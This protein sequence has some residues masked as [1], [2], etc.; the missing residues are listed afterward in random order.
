VK[1][2]KSID[3][4]DPLTK[5]EVIKVLNIMEVKEVQR[6]DKIFSKG[7]EAKELFLLDIGLV[8]AIGEDLYTITPGDCFGEEAL[9]RNIPHAY[10]AM[11]TVSPTVIGV[12]DVSKLRS[13]V[14]TS[15]MVEIIE[16][17]EEP[18][19]HLA[20]SDFVWSWLN[21]C[22]SDRKPNSVTPIGADAPLASPRTPGRSPRTTPRS[23][24]PWTPKAVKDISERRM[25][26]SVSSSAFISERRMS[27]R[28]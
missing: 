23:A 21:C 15:S 11:A 22:V 6:G 1:A 9:F 24:R 25:S 14:N 12:I 27:F 17:R 28:A 10:T 2:L 8:S 19:A 3:I 5:K 20:E 18:L 13:I 4:F 26:S 16:Q 7:E